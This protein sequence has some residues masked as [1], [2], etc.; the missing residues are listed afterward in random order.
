MAQNESR[1]I[2]GRVAT[3][4]AMGIAG[5]IGVSA[6]VVLQPGSACDGI[7]EQ[8]APRIEANLEI[9]RNR[10]AFAVEQQTIQALSESA[11]KVGLHLKTCCAVL[12]AGELDAGEF[13]QCLD[14]ASAY[15]RHIE[16]VAQTV[17]E[18]AQ[19]RE[20]GSADV[21]KARVAD[22]R[23]G[24]Q[25]ATAD[26]ERFSR[27]VARIRPPEPVKPGPAGSRGSETE[28]NNAAAQATE[29][30]I[31]GQVDAEVATA[32]DADFYKLV[33]T[34][35][36]RDRVLLRMESLSES[37]RPYMTVYNANWSKM[38]EKYDYTYG[39]SLAFSFE[40]VVG[41][42]YFV[43][44]SPWESQGDYQLTLE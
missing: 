30:R 42:Q 36:L 3:L 17:N 18:V 19:A 5:L 14:Q 31:S 39:A 6:I 15:D 8:T 25:A 34:K 29:I 43:Q 44:V 22:I 32:E 26:A 2:T 1:R 41:E 23:Q 4:I 35:P 27:E 16:Q 11:Q 9:I 13:Q 33:A 38:M 12:K 40:A 10:G 28:P 20:A 7:F 21:V 24:I 37:L